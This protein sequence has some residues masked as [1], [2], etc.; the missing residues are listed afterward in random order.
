MLCALGAAA[1]Y[2]INIVAARIAA[3]AGLPGPFVIFHRV[4]VMLAVLGVV[5]FW[6][7]EWPRVEPSER[8]AM[9]VVIIAS[10]TMG[11]A[12]LSSVMFIPVTLAVVIFYTYPVLIVLAGPLVAGETLTPVRLGIVAAAFAGLALVIGP[13]FGGLDWRGIALAALASLATTAQF[14]AANRTR[15]TPLIGKL[16][17]LHLGVLPIAGLVAWGTGTMLPPAELARA[18]WAVGITIGAYVV[19]IALQFA[20]LARIPASL[21]GLMFC[22]EPVVAALASIV[23]LGERLGPTQIAGGLMVLAAIA[24]TVM[25]GRRDP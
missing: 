2:G 9:V 15:R 19:A 5:A 20:A 25:T 18:P 4:F 17:V 13:S 16:I 14:F 24:A 1:G 3:D 11:L 8:P 23:V 21:A 10:A 7:R 12:Y 22:L 6:L